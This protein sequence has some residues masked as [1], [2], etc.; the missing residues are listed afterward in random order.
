MNQTPVAALQLREVSKRFGSKAAL[1]GLDLHAAPG[2][3]TA[4]LGPNGA[5]KTTMI[6]CCTGLLAPDAGSVTVL[7]HPAGSPEASTRIGV[8]PQSTGAWSGIGAAE[9]LRYLAGMYANPQPVDQLVEL[10]GIADFAKTPYRRLSGGQQQSV[11]LA[12]ALVGRPELVFLDE[13]TAGMDPHVRRHTWGIIRSLRADGVAVVLTTHAMDEAAQL[14]DDVWMVDRGRVVVH[15]T[16]AELTR[17]DSLE[18]VFLA[19]TTARVGGR[20]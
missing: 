1:D 9:L 19:N 16:V 17:T 2:E 5:G 6:R 3:I 4:V 7:G 18:D 11:N 12:G 10:L 8:M 14:A 13:P 15:G 20:P